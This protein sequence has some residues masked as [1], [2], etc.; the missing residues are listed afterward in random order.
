M[1]KTFVTA[2]AFILS[3][4]P[5]YAATFNWT[6]PTTR[7][8]GVALPL[9][10]IGGIS[11]YDT[12]APLPGFPGTPVAC[13]IP[14]LPPTTATGSCTAT[15]IAGHSFVAVYG[16]TSSPSLISAPSNTATLP[17]V[18]LPPSPITNLTVQ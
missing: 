6:W 10:Q 14:T 5:L 3:G 1:R 4:A 8:N 7:I 17:V 13:T 16:D 15:V 12:S 11:I 2:I 18:L 9:S